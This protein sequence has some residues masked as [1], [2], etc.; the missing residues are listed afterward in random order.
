MML[1]RLEA[2]KGRRP[3]A[4]EKKAMSWG[5]DGGRMGRPHELGQMLGESFPLAHLVPNVKAVLLPGL[6]EK[7]DGPVVEDV[8][9]GVG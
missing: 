2:G 8:Q 5:G 4:P 1:L 6:I 7:A 3:K 9:E